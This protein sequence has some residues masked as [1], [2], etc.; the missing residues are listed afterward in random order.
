MGVEAEP[1]YR[2]LIDFINKTT[3]TTNEFHL[4]T[5]I[6]RYFISEIFSNKAQ[7]LSLEERFHRM[8]PF[9]VKKLQKINDEKL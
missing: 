8:C 7:R 6:K 3:M 5:E 4:P 9:K 2:E 1:D